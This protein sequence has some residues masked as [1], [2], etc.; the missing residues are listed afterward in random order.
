MKL[1]IFSEDKKLKA[2]SDLKNQE[3]WLVVSMI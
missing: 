2:I 3:I 1:K